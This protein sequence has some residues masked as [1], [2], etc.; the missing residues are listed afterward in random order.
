M[1]PM[2]ALCD[3]S[4]GCSCTEKRK[5]AMRSGLYIEHGTRSTYQKGC[6][7]KLCRA[8]NTQVTRDQRARS[9]RGAA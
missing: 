4:L 7:C 2:W 8:A 9:G 5:R 3:G 1:L 6:R